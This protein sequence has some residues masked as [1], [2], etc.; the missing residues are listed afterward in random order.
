MSLIFK[1]IFRNPFSIAYPI[2][3]LITIMLTVMAASCSQQWALE[4]YAPILGDWETER[5]IIMSIHR[6]GEEIVASIKDRKEYD[7][8]AFQAGEALITAITPLV[9]GGYRGVM[10]LPGPRKPVAVK[11]GLVSRD[12]LMIITWDNR[13]K[14]KTMK[15]RR[16]RSSSGI[17]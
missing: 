16:V 2:V 11:L 12:T 17:K 6:S 4:H 14:S 8:E 15:W 9:D 5:G 3:G 7:A 10:P 13:T 1:S